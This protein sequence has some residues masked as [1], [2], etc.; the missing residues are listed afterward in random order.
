MVSSPT[1]YTLASNVPAKINYGT[2]Q[3]TTVFINQRK[4]FGKWNSLGSY[5]FP[6][7]DSKTVELSND[8]NGVVISDAIRFVYKGPSENYDAEA[9][10]APT[11]VKVIQLD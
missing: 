2:G 8:A 6:K 4:N 7:G 10:A 3:D 11:G 5:A 1:S 9:P